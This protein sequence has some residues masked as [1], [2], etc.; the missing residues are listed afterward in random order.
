MHHIAGSLVCTSR[1]SPQHQ[2]RRGVHPAHA[3]KAEQPDTVAATAAAEAGQQAASQNEL[4]AG[5]S[6]Q[7]QQA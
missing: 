2:P 1:S 7:H 4:F 6:I 5:A 3:P